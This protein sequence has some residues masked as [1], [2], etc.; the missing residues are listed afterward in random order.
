MPQV[1][2]PAAP[3]GHGRTLFALH[4]TA[5]G[6]TETAT[7]THGDVRLWPPG[8]ALL[9]AMAVLQGAAWSGATGVNAL[10]ESAG[11]PGAAGLVR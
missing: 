5:P 6:P 2:P 9:F 11:S 7:A 1:G 4:R 8:L 10:A 3:A